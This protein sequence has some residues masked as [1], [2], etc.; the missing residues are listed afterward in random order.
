MAK[1]IYEIFDEFE[2]ASGK[3][4]KMKVI[5]N[6]LSKTLVDVLQMTFHPN[7][8]WLIT[9]MPDN[10][11]VPDT[12]VGD[13]AGQLH[14]QIRKLYLFQKGN[15]TAENLTP[16]KRNELLLQLLESLEFREAEVV[17]GIFSKDQGVRGL[18][19]RFVKEA[20]PNLIP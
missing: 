5:E 6:N 12:L 3:E 2:A 9:E 14:N 13:S 10:Y 7:F 1:N 16:A 17:I 18:T 4:E 11:K 19:Y 15:P 8:Q 20:F